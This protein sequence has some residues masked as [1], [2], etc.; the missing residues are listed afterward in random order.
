MKL[1]RKVLI[2]ATSRKTR[3]G[4]TSVIKAHE[5]GR[6]W[7]KFHCKWIETHRDGNALMKLYYFATALLKYV[8]LIPFYSIVH[9]H[10]ATES[11]AK[12]KYVFFLIA[13]ALHKKVIFHFHPCSEDI[14]FVPENVKR[15]RNLFMRADLVLVLSQQ[16][17]RWIKQTLGLDENIKVLY[18]PCPIV[19]QREDLRKNTILFAG[20]VIERKGY[21]DLLR[22]FALISN[23]YSN[24]R[25]VF[26]GNGEINKA[27]KIAQDLHIDDKVEFLGW[28][29]GKEKEKAFQFASIYCLASSGEGFPMGLLDAWAYRIPCVTTPVGGIPDIVKNGVNGLVFKVGDI[30]NLSKQLE[31]LIETKSLRKKIVMET[32]I[33]V[34][35][36]FSQ[37]YINNELGRIYNN[38]LTEQIDN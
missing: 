24:W 33:F 37:D 13:K 34:K 30:D 8:F 36:A 20:S 5:Q 23:K 19:N 12:R 38:V 32:D 11:S 3:G 17:Q 21:E 10:V 22:S 25:L 4:I 7:Q 14:L 28:I 18:N 26:A 31:L 27:K 29:S 16:W 2:V 35:G 9:I 6:Q 1:N 15:Y